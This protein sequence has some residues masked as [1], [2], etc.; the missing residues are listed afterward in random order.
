[1][2]QISW[3]FLGCQCFC[4]LG[5]VVPCILL[6]KTEFGLLFLKHSGS[7]KTMLVLVGMS[8]KHRQDYCEVLLLWVLCSLFCR[9]R[10]PTSKSELAVCRREVKN[11]NLECWNSNRQ[12]GECVRVLI[13]IFPMILDREFYRSDTRQFHKGQL[14][15]T[16]PL[17]IRIQQY[18]QTCCHRHDGRKLA[19][20]CCQYCL[21]RLCWLNP[22]L[23][24]W[25]R[26]ILSLHLIMLRYRPSW[27]APFSC[28]LEYL[29]THDCPI[30][31]VFFKD[32]YCLFKGHVVGPIDTTGRLKKMKS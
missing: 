16:R 23:L 13:Q 10:T 17:E 24:V 6:E 32:I 27:W 30:L 3:Q 21:R 11:L 15:W 29:C 19:L 12:L 1:M 5:T 31:T 25:I 26:Y 22:V 14:Y 2:M 28:R 7:R 20:I 18:Q 4:F 8:G 9:A